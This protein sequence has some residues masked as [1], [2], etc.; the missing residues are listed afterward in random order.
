MAKKIVS[1][2][3]ALAMLATMVTVGMVSAFA[4]EEGTGSATGSQTIN[5]LDTE[6]LANWDIT[7]QFTTG[8]QSYAGKVDFAGVTEYVVPDSNVTLPALEG[9]TGALVLEK[10]NAYSTDGKSG[11]V[12]FD[13]NQP[14]NFGSD[15]S[16]L[17]TDF[18]HGNT[19]VLSATDDTYVGLTLGDYSVRLVRFQEDAMDKTISSTHG[20]QYAFRIALYVKNELYACSARIDTSIKT[21]LYDG[22][23]YTHKYDG[24]TGTGDSGPW[25]RSKNMYAG[26]I[27]SFCTSDGVSVPSTPSTF[28]AD[29]AWKDIKIVFKDGALTI[30]NA[31][32]VCNF[33]VVSE[34]EGFNGDVTT[35][36]K[37][38]TPSFDL[39][40][41]GVTSFNGVTPSVKLQNDRGVMN[42]NPTG[43]FRLEVT[44]NTMATNTQEINFL[45]STNIPNWDVNRDLN[46]SFAGALNLSQFNLEGI[47]GALSVV[48][49][50]TDSSASV[51]FKYKDSID[52]GSDFSI[53]MTAFMC[54][55]IGKI[56]STITDNA[57]ISLALGNYSVRLVR[58]K[59]DVDSTSNK[60]NR[61]EFRVALYGPNDTLLAVTNT[62][63]TETYTDLYGGTPYKSNA[64]LLQVQKKDSTTGE[65]TQAVGELNQYLVD[66]S[67]KSDGTSHYTNYTDTGYGNDSGWRD[68]TVTVKDGKLSVSLANNKVCSFAVIDKNFNDNVTSLDTFD[69][70]A[71]ELSQLGITSFDGITPVVSCHNDNAV[72]KNKPSAV[73]RLKATINSEPYE[74]DTR[75][76]PYAANTTVDSALSSNMLFTPDQ[77]A[78]WNNEGTDVTVTAKVGGVVKQTISKED[79]VPMEVSDK[80]Y[81][82]AKFDFLTPDLYGTTVEYVVSATTTEDTQSTYTKQY[83]VKDY[84]VNQMKDCHDFLALTD[85]KALLALQSAGISEPTA[86][87]VSAYKEKATKL[88]NLCMS[89][90]D[91]A[92]SVRA[93]AV[94]A[95]KSNV[96]TSITEGLDSY[97]EE[98]VP[99]PWDSS[100]LVKGSTRGDNNMTAVWQH[101]SLNFRDEIGL[102]FD[103]TLSDGTTPANCALYRDSTKVVDGAAFIASPMNAT[104]N[105]AVARISPT[106][107]ETRYDYVVANPDNYD[108]FS[109]HYSISVQDWVLHYIGLSTTIDLEKTCLTK[110]MTYGKAAKAYAEPESSN[111]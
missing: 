101:V 27:N 3:C 110:M 31:A 95:G 104:W 19:K 87:M 111:A 90:L 7:R 78:V 100:G 81:Q 36:T 93:W 57:Y 34:V 80:L 56:T 53:L 98:F 49:L 32:G 92:E 88:G 63:A 54:T 47:D 73:F 24:I 18:I 61:C 38:N 12:R 83:S 10:S 70:K 97:S 89:I 46:W 99:T 29:A 107:F 43:V 42:G 59:E 55:N 109:T 41:M 44:V 6:H 62:I 25:V 2:L 37:F 17:M 79:F 76:K 77:V 108:E 40:K 65:I 60:W 68:I 74:S 75:L 84:C 28:A 69:T 96:E 67:T 94:G 11:Y 35:L 64:T 22:T 9:I 45:D 26:Y 102:N 103:F 21:S 23:V 13:Y 105:R 91:Y 16:I 15:F 66:N 72:M 50:N 14:V 86:E 51:N 71:F 52:F 5:L 85:D 8:K 48:R 4:E 58:F 33:A 106:A 30:E 39:S 20:G 82:A 1:I